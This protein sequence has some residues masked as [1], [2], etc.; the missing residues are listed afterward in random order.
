MCPRIKGYVE[1]LGL[2][3]EMQYADGTDF[4][5]TSHDF[6]EDVMNVLAL[7]SPNTVWCATD[8]E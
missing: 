2:P 4:V 3:V 5:S 1:E 7:S 8:T 6:L